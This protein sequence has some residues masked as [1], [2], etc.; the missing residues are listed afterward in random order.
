M[1]DCES[2][3]ARPGGNGGHAPATDSAAHP[4]PPRSYLGP[5]MRL[6]RTGVA[7]VLLGLCVLAYGHK[8]AVVPEASDGLVQEHHVDTVAEHACNVAEVLS[9]EANAPPTDL[10]V[11]AE[12]LLD[13]VVSPS[14][15][16][17]TLTRWL[18]QGK[19]MIKEKLSGTAPLTF[20]VCNA[21]VPYEVC[22]IVA[23]RRKS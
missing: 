12:N 15:S 7:A 16:T 17:A 19:D 18:C 11:I 5:T 2:P 20:C 10:H 21:G 8:D 14:F 6:G 1:R 13:E 4:S 23:A 22:S 3:H 9:A